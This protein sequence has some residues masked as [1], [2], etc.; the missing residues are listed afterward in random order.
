M[1]HSPTEGI[2]GFKNTTSSKS[3][4]RSATSR[5]KYGIADDAFLPR[6][7]EQCKDDE[8]RGLVYILYFS[9]MHGS[10]LTA[11]SIENL[12]REGMNHYYLVWKRTKTKAYMEAPVPNDKVPIIESFLSGRK[13][14]LQWYNVLLHRIGERAGYDAVST[15]TFRHTR[16][17][18]LIK[19]GIPLPSVAQLMGCTEEVVMR[20]YGK[21]SEL[22]KREMQKCE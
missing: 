6:M 4:L 5:R 20:N 7:I 15:M 16:C 17:I 21:Y 10:V 13:K 11:L 8:E 14:S 1:K 12:K 22:Q 3:R 19:D 2:A 18:N 9:G